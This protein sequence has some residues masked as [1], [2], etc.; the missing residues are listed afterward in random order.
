MTLI[1]LSF[2]VLIFI[3]LP[4]MLALGIVIGRSASSKEHHE[5]LLLTRRPIVLFSSLPLHLGEKTEVILRVLTQ[6]QII[7]G[8][9]T[10]TEP[11]LWDVVRL[12][13][14]LQVTYGWRCSLENVIQGLCAVIQ[15]QT[16]EE[17]EKR[18][19]RMTQVGTI[20]RI[21][22]VSSPETHDASVAP[23]SA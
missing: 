20:S 16:I 19:K 5:K 1:N 12:F 13:L 15:R 2:V 11:T 18:G 9:N 4:G 6:V 10:T 8:T 21:E 22:E 17:R 23:V 14:A 7:F 3:G